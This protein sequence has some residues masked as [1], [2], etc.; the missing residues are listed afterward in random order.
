MGYPGHS[1]SMLTMRNMDQY[2]TKRDHL[3]EGVEQVRGTA[4]NTSQTA[5]TR[6][7]PAALPPSP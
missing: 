6:C 5:S 7:A 1:L 2:G 4:I 3:G